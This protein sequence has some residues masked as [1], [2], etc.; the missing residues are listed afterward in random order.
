VPTTG[1]Y[2]VSRWISFALVN[3]LFCGGGSNGANT[4]SF[5]IPTRFYEDFAPGP[6]AA[7]TTRLANVPLGLKTT[8]VNGD[9]SDVKSGCPD[10]SPRRCPYASAKG[11]LCSS[12]LVR[13]EVWWPRSVEHTG[14][15][16]PFIG[17]TPV[18]GKRVTT[19]HLPIV[20]HHVRLG[21]SV[22]D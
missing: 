21:E 2:I 18:C 6:L 16:K 4:A 22:L 9:E 19:S 7:N 14:G 13:G 17:Q 15:K 8:I 3:S 1:S 5:D 20:A 11:K 12:F 10:E